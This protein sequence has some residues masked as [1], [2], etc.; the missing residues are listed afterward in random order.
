MT[1]EI[2][3]TT[4]ALSVASAIISGVGVHLWKERR[5]A[6]A[7]DAQ[8]QA[9]RGLVPDEKCKG[10]HEQW[11]EKLAAGDERMNVGA[12]VDAFVVTWLP[13]ICEAIDIKP[14]DCKAMKEQAANLLSKV[15]NA[16]RAR[17]GRSREGSHA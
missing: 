8:A 13:V 2:M 3:A 7:R 11:E 16:G 5:A 6:V 10:C 4:V 1:P 15:M 12:E 14:D 9:Q 17:T